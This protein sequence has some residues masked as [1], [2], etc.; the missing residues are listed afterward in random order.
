MSVKDLSQAKNPDLIAS[1]AAMHHAAQ[2]ARD[3]AIQFNTG[4]VVEDDDGNILHI[5]AE[6]LRKE[7]DE[8][9]TKGRHSADPSSV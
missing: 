6:T 1:V 5:D 4:I 9:R 7:R 3:T 8:Q 2:V